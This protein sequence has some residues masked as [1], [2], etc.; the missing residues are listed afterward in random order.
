M[1]FA[2]QKYWQTIH[3]KKTLSFFKIHLA[4]KIR[5][6]RP[7]SRLS[8]PWLSWGSNGYQKPL[9]ALA[10]WRFCWPLLRAFLEYLGMYDSGHV[11]FC[12]FSRS[13]LPWWWLVT[14]HLQKWAILCFPR[15]VFPPLLLIWTVEPRSAWSQQV[16]RTVVS[17]QFF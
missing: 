11:E 10:F 7:P 16:G 14:F 9:A 1:F 8:A 5:R 3:V 4:P 12:F 2:I 13:D 17:F 15:H 6:P